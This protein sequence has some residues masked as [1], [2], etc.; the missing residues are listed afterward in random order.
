MNATQ[1]APSDLEVT[2]QKPLRFRYFGTAPSYRSQAFASRHRFAFTR[3]RTH[4]CAAN[5]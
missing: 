1:I 5:S 4:L 3:F 2:I